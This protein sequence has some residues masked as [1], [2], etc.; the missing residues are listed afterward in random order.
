MELSAID[1]LRLARRLEG[2]G[3][4]KIQAEEIARYLRGAASVAKPDLAR[5]SEMDKLPHQ[6]AEELAP[7]QRLVG[8]DLDFLRNRIEGLRL[9]S[10]EQVRRGRAIHSLLQWILA[11]LAV[12]ALATIG[13]LVFEVFTTSQAA[14]AHL[15]ASSLVQ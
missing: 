4:A 2:L 7:W 9:N 10:T 13:L 5:K 14:V 6:I 1:S 3:L 8:D 15:P 12:I 11:L